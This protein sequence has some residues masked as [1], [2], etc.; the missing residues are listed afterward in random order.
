MNNRWNRTI[1]KFA[2]PIYDKLFNSG[3]FLRARKEIF[4]DTK[5]TKN[6]NILFVGVGT[7]ADLELVN[8]NEL[9]ITAIDYSDDML[10][11]ARNKFKG[12]SIQFA[13]MDAQHMSFSDNHFDL[14]V[15]SLIL[16]VVPDPHKC[17]KEMLRVLK[18]AG[19]I[20]VFDKFTPK[21]KE[22][23]PMK[24][25]IRPVIKLLGTDI[26]VNFE[27]LCEN[28]KDQLFVTE[29]APVMFNGMYRKIIVKKIEASF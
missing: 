21:D 25:A 3:Q 8:H 11:K 22:L 7:G 15:G 27:K 2:A 9:H 19:E 1:Y 18:P 28:Y 4:Q 10:N 20:I 12:S 5:F 13:K 16:S 17:L 26:G 23:S 6:Q 24:K 14:I 29:D